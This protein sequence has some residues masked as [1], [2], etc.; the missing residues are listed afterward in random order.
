MAKET[1]VSSGSTAIGVDE[2]IL[3]EQART[4][5]MS[6]FG[7]LV[8]R[9][10][11]RVLNTCWRV[12]GN[13]EDARDLTQ[14]A[15]LHAM[16][17]IGSFRQQANF[18]TWLFRI[19]MNLSISHRRKA[20]RAVKLSLHG[21]EGQSVCDDPSA[22]L[23]G[24]V[25][26]DPVDPPAKLSA[27]EVETLVAEGLEQLDD[28]HRAVIVLRDIESF[29]YQQIAE[30]LELPVGTVKSRLHRARMELRGRLERAVSGK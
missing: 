25:S 4:G 28:D 18:Y 7:R 26:N 30:I 20:A 10:Q 23:H 17:K 29:D 6:A 22:R 9:Y 1:M 15:F 19:A 2:A 16:E 21:P 3:V 11:D 8:T 5:D 24:R 12:C 27:R 13:L 14:E